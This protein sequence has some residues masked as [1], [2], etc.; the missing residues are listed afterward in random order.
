MQ[1][2]KNRSWIYVA[3]VRLAGFLGYSNMYLLKKKDPIHRIRSKTFLLEKGEIKISCLALKFEFMISFF[4][5]R[6][7][8]PNE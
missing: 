6:I 3:F 1:K 4:F 5:F 7:F 2:Q 8:F